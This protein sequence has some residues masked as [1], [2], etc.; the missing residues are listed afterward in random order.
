MQYKAL[1][2]VFAT[3]ALAASSDVTAIDPALES[4][5]TLP[6]WVEEAIST[7]EPT[8]WAS[9]FRYDSAFALSVELAEMAGT[10]P[11][12]YNN[13]PASVLEF[14]STRDAAIE[15]YGATATQNDAFTTSGSTATATATGSSN[16]D[17][18]S[19]STGGAPA[20]TGALYVGLAG[21]AG[22]L[23]LSHAL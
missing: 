6:I 12:W 1:P 15:S 3:V 16:A 20:A 10:M 8:A 23:G 2:M 21:A 13:L 18:T 4:L 5:V 17:T 22:I 19:V 11:A 7:A 9:S 14:L